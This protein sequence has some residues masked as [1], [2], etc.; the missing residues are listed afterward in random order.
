MKFWWCERFEQYR[1]KH[2][3][4][5]YIFSITLIRIETLS[6]DNFFFRVEKGGN[7]YKRRGR[8]RKRRKKN[9]RNN[10]NSNDSISS[11]N[12][13]GPEKVFYIIH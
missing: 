11:H 9:K 3:T 12:D 5:T 6:V 4:V 8:M 10:T 7:G 13:V 2:F 1:N